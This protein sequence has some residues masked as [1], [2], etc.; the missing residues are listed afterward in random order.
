M[1]TIWLSYNIRGVSQRF[2]LKGLEDDTQEEK[3]PVCGP[4]AGLRCPHLLL[5]PA[6]LANYDDNDGTLA[7]FPD[8]PRE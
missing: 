2:L 6:W 5:Q 4:P 3:T 8:A 1:V 7:S